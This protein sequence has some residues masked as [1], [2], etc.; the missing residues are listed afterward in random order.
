MNTELDFLKTTPKKVPKS[1]EFL[2]N[3]IADAVA[4]SNDDKI[5]KTE[6]AEKIIFYQKKVKK[7]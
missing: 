5:V 4:K 6:T 3:K 2:G 7:Y 1:C